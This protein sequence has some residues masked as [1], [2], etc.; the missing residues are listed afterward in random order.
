MAPRN[1]KIRKAAA[2]KAESAIAGASSAAR[3]GKPSST[4]GNFALHS[5]SM[6][7][8]DLPLRVTLCS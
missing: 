2:R 4:D 1:K 6:T 7:G 5:M 8:D 3:S